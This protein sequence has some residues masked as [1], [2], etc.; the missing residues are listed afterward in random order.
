MQGGAGAA[1]ENKRTPY[2][3]DAST[4]G[5]GFTTGTPWYTA[6]PDEAPGV[7][8]ASQR[9]DPASLWHAYRDLIALRHASAPLAGGDA[10]RPAVAGGGDGAFALLRGAGGARVLFVA[11][12]AAAPSGAFTVA[13]PGSPAVLASSGLAGAPAAAGGLVTVPG[14]DARGWAFLALQ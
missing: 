6:T 8:L 1:D 4:P 13:A 14:L 12:F 10:T 11:N 5:H 9:A 2:R 3:W 7:D